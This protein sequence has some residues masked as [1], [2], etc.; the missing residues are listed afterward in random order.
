MMKL[1]KI[2]VF[3]M[4]LLLVAGTVMAGGGKESSGKPEVNVW[5]SGSDNIRIIYEK[6]ADSF[7]KNPEY[8]QYCTVKIQFIATG[9]GAQT[10]QDKILAAYKAGQKNTT[11]DLVESGDDQIA[12]YMSE[13]GPEMFLRYDPSKISNLREVTARPALGAEYFVPYRGTTVVMAYNSDVIRTPPKTVQDLTN[14]IKQNPGRFVYNAAGTGG[15]GD[16]FI[17][18]SIYNFMPTEAFMSSD[19]KWMAQW[20]KGFAY[21]AEIHPFMYKSSGRVV[22]P[23]KNQGTL[24]LLASKEIDMCPAWADQAISGVKNGS[25]PASIK[26]YQIEPSLTGAVNTF[27]IPSFG[28]YPEEAY[29]FIDFMLSAEAQNLLLAELAAIPLI[30]NSK[31]DSGNAATVRDLDV[32]NF[33]T[34]SIGSLSTELNRRWN[35]TIVTLP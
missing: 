21:L 33:R 4:V 24:D 34:Q 35:E 10:I 2:A 23:N 11:F 1:K 17:R 19:T 16:S 31:L 26:I 27:G 15:A 7:N 3:L 12:A 6:L 14:W 8:N 13:G 22:Y 28:R 30:P 9:G 25:L 5:V 18:S 29:R 20:D 32:N